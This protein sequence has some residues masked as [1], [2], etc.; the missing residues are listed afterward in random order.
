[1]HDIEIPESFDPEWLQ[2]QL[3]ELAERLDVV[4]LQVPESEDTSDIEYALKIVEALR[5]YA[6]Y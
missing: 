2:L 1:M 5:E 6:G 4:E 3:R